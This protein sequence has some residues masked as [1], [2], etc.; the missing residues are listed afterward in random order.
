MA[1]IFYGITRKECKEVTSSLKENGLLEII[2]PKN[3]DNKMLAEHFK[4]LNIDE[5]A[6]KQKKAKDIFR[7][8]VKKLIVKYSVEFSI[9]FIIDLRFM[10]K[11]KYI[12]NG[13]AEVHG[14]QFNGRVSICAALQFCPDDLVEKIIRYAVCIVAIK[15]EEL[16]SNIKGFGVGSYD[17][18]TGEKKIVGSINLPESKYSITLNPKVLNQIQNDYDLAFEQFGKEMEKQMINYIG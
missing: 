16:C 7:K 8:K 6:D 4:S 3:V 18:M 2:A 9:P 17:I 1:G 10:A 12:C 15:Y 13:E 11:P 5:I 14:I